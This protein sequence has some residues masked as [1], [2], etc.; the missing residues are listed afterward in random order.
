MSGDLHELAVD[1]ALEQGLLIRTG[2]G[3]TAS[4]ES[5]SYTPMGAMSHRSWPRREP[6]GHDSCAW[7]TEHVITRVY[8]CESPEDVR[9][10]A[11]SGHFP[12]TAIRQVESVIAPLSA[13]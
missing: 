12:V 9:E 6:L 1:H 13:V 4:L 3:P 5:C 2:H 7:I 8:I 11:T 10:H